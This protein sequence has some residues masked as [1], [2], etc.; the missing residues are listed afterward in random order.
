MKVLLAVDGSSCS[1]AA[2]ESL[3]HTQ[4]DKDTEIQVISVV[5]FY[6][7]LP[8]VEGRRKR[9]SKRQ[10]SWSMRRLTNLK[11]DSRTIRFRAP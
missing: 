7:P 5:D 8:S 3:L 11:P 4:C 9:K 10:V 2:A 1:Q 6:E